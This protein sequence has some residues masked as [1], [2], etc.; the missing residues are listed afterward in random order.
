MSIDPPIHF[1]DLPRSE[2]E[3]AI[4]DL[5]DKARLVL[6]TQGR[7]RSLL[8]ATRSIGEE[9]DLPV[10]LRRI[11]Q[12]AVD[13]VGARCGALGV[14][15]P[16]G[17]L[18]EFVSVGLEADEQEQAEHAHGQEILRR[19][20][21]DPVRLEH[22]SRD[23][24]SVGF[25]E[26]LTPLDSFLGVPI[27][28]RGEVFGN[29]YLCDRHGGP[30][31]VEDEELLSALAASAGIAIDNARL[32]GETQRRQR[33]AVASAEVSAALLDVD[34]ADP[35]G[36]I[37]EAVAG[38]TDA[39]LVLLIMPTSVD[40]LAVE[41]AWGE[42]AD[43]VSGR[44]F[45]KEGT[46]SGSV[47][48][49]GHPLLA[50]SIPTR[51][52]GDVELLGG[53][54][55]V[56]PLAGGGRPHGALAIIRRLGAPRFQASDLDMATDFAS[57]ASVALE[58]RDARRARERV[59]LLE[60]RSRIAR[61]LHDNVIQRL[62]GA[63]LALHSIDI[64]GVP[65]AAGTKIAM[66]GELVD[67]AIAEIRKSVFALRS[68]QPDNGTPRHR[69]LDVLGEVASAFPAPPRITFEGHVDRW[70]PD[71]LVDDLEAVV[72]EG[73]ANAARHA[74]A[75]A[76]E[77]TVAADERQIAV[78]IADDGVGPN[79]S[80]RSSGIG[81]LEDRARAWGGVSSL[82]PGESGGAVLEWRVPT[83]TGRGAG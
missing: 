1:P 18:E 38:M 80:S 23:P 56:L 75:Q 59:A 35:L 46:V 30:F 69:L 21:A 37:A 71:S 6:S 76:V 81:N 3:R 51:T 79:G 49:S 60:D 39:G 27:R 2:L 42:G 24:R 5:V 26:G 52:Y 25:P 10:V 4:E 31:T 57:H 9:L 12:A 36:L 65:P 11:V 44:V 20:T 41:Y 61:D 28:V 58:L 47:I 19:I 48:D 45:P 17:D 32:F 62:F 7:L 13:L 63:G 83:P 73:L 14:M 16:E 74:E 43:A 55:M 29:L 53:P 8:A 67:Q 70:A 64:A 15:G 33:W 40:A 72:R 82:A 66:V 22:V 54:A 78:R 68:T 77:V 34:G 50:T